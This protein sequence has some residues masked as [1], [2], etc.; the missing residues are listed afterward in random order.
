MRDKVEDWLWAGARIVWVIYPITR[1]ATLYRSLDEITHLTETDILDGEHVAPGFA[2]RV[3][4]LF[5]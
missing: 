3:G 5:A 1:T 4:E 2:R